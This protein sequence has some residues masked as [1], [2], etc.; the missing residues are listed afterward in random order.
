MTNQIIAI[1]LGA[2]ST[3]AVCLQ[4]DGE[5]LSLVSYTIQDCPNFGKALSQEQLAKHLEA[6]T[7]AVSPKTR[8]IILAVSATDSVICHAEMPLIETSQMRKMVKLNPKLY[9][10][11]DLP[12]HS[13]DCFVLHQGAGAK[14]DGKQVRK[15]KTLVVAIKNQLLQNL[16]DAARTTG[17]KLEAVAASQTGAANCFVMSKEASQDK[18]VALVDI[19]FSHSTISLLVNGEITLTR[20]VNIGADK[21]THGLAEAMNITYSVAEG[22][23]QI[24]PEKVNA[25]LKGLI[26][27]LCHE[28]SNSIHFFEQQQD[29]KVSE[30]YV[31]GGSARS[32]FIIE[33]LQSELGLPCESWDPTRSL[34]LDLS[35][36]QS[37]SLKQEGPQLTVAI[38]AAL[39]WFTPGLAAIDLLAEQK[40][41]AEM[42]SRDPM[43]R[44]YALAAALVA[45]ILG[46][47][48]FVMV[49][50]SKAEKLLNE[51]TAEMNSLQPSFLEADSNEKKLGEINR[52]LNVLDQ[53]STNRFLWA[54]ALNA[55]QH[56]VVDNFQMVRLQINQQISQIR[57]I[58]S[59][60]NVNKVV[61]VGRQAETLEQT[62]FRIQ[63]KSFVKP[64]AA[65]NLMRA[66]STSPWFKANLRAEE[67]LRLTESQA[68]I[69]DPTNPSK[70]TILFTVEC[71]AEHKL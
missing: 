71:Y 48:A 26:S 42:R 55:L 22:L 66:I 16:Q 34:K 23:K 7:Q 59:V 30:V 45:L 53:L 1:D 15:A 36:A 49:K 24:M 58:P 52:T 64:S 13:F 54:A 25:Q 20:V 61:I 10:Q 18:V 17:L 9:F 8:E 32:A 40:E 47:Y 11:E 35:P 14:A 60:T 57:A 19:G 29:K 5:T 65:E 43:K 31:S 56:T 4:K 44:G 2:R 12:N 63:A 51:K 70:M 27:P 41:E 62:I 50:G 6:I 69:V 38:G 33:I 46:W 37:S 67:P 39:A 3:K 21:F 28:L 68:P